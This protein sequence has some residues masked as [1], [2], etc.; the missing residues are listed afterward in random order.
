VVERRRLEIGVR[1]ALG[2]TSRDI[3]GLVLARGLALVGLA[4]PIGLVCAV[5]GAG[6]LQS[7]LFGIEPL[8]PT[9]FAAVLAGVPV[10]ALAACLWPARRA[11]AIEPLDALRED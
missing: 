4:V 8:D 2:A 10:V 9:T 11:V 6:L 1:R 7:L 3:S 5:A